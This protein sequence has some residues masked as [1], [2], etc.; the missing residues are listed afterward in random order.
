MFTVIPLPNYWKKS[1]N[2]NINE[3]TYINLEKNIEI[4]IHPSCKYFEDQIFYHKAEN[5]KNNNAIFDLKRMKFYDKLN[6][7]YEIDFVSFIV[8]FS[9][10]KENKKNDYKVINLAFGDDLDLKKEEITEAN[11]RN[12]MFDLN[13]SN[14]L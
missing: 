6:R 7:P 8:E 5:I 14:L 10:D 11:L 1:F 2:Y 9:N 4:P 13:N 12:S 3:E